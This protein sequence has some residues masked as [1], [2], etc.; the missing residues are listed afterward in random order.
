MI[1]NTKSLMRDKPDKTLKK[2]FIGIYKIRCRIN[3][4]VFV[5]FSKDVDKKLREHKLALRRGKHRVQTM[6]IDFNDYAENAFEF[7]VI[8]RFTKT[9]LKTKSVTQIDRLLRS[10]TI[11]WKFELHAYE[12]SNSYNNR[13]IR[14]DRSFYS[15]L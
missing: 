3:N 13:T 14:K 7:K 5:A 12:L 10:R 8:E 2:S 11:H 15:K 9:F 1:E 4:K 6:Q